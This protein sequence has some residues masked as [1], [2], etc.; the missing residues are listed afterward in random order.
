MKSTMRV[1]SAS[2][3]IALS[4]I[5]MAEATMA[6]VETVAATLDA[7]AA[8]R[9]QGLV[10]GKIASN[11]TN[12]AGSD[13][14]ALAL[15][16]ALRNGT[17]ATLAYS[18]PAAGGTTTTTTTTT[19]TYDPPTGKMGWGNVKIALALA[20]DSLARAGITKPTAEQ[21][22][23][24]LNGGDVTVKNA[25]G[26]T[27]TT[28]LKGVLQMRAS[29]M[30]WGQIAQASGTKLGPVVSG[31]K[32][33]NSKIAALPATTTSTTAT[34]TTTAK[35]VGA[36]TSKGITTA[37]GA[38]APATHGKGVSSGVVT[39]AGGAANSAHGNAYGRGVV[40]AAGGSANVGATVSASQGRGVGVVAAG[41][42]AAGAISTAQGDNGNG[43]SNGK[44]KGGGGG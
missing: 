14:N 33:A 30:G 40:T 13:K 24:A 43:K 19:T 20:Q 35:G 29:G 39:A 37:A 1:L 25:D 44:G 34:G 28:T 7:T 16:N 26:T 6:E 41:G 2:L 27:T 38:S 9:G 12:L 23:A 32:M 36:P 3:I 17:D 22:Q 42:A 5:A 8:N 31:L 11:F 4:P 15:V 18:A 21:L 10:A